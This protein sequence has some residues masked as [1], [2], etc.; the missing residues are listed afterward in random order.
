MIFVTVGTDMPFD[1]LV[2]AVD[3]W[4]GETG[5]TDLF[6][7]VG[8]GGRAPSFFE[9]SEMLEPDEFAEK[10]SEASIVIAHAGMG[11]ILTALRSEKPILVMPRRAS[12]GEQRNDHQL[13]TARHLKEMGALHVAMDIAELRDR[14]E[15]IDSL[16]SRR[17]VGPYASESLLG[18]LI[19]FL[20]ATSRT[21]EVQSRNDKWS[22]SELFGPIRR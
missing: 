14:L 11:T 16:Q 1:R 5:R 15:N 22:R 6:A 8:I 13:A 2:T 21:I 9:S 20:N 10:M 4:A 18:T 12:L 17:R 3:D 19:Q 7:Q